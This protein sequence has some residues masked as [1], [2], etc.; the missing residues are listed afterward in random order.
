MQQSKTLCV[1]LGANNGKSGDIAARPGQLAT[2]PVRTGSP[3][4]TMTIGMVVV[5]F[6]AASAASVPFV[7][8]IST[9][10]RTSSFANGWRSSALPLASRRSMTRF[11]PSVQPSSLSGAYICWSSAGLGRSP[12]DKTPMR[13]TVVAVC[14]LAASGA[15]MMPAATAPMN[16]RRSITEAFR[17]E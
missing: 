15:L 4:E 6:L 11:L 3:T 10:S 1:K 12:D 16:V 2:I 8:M 17:C 13:R 9:L 14:V 7:T 5:A